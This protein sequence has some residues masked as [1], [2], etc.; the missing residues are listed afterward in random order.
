MRPVLITDE[1]A[2]RFHL[3]IR[4]FDFFGGTAEKGGLD[5]QDGPSGFSTK[6]G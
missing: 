1:I 2:P 4:F 6:G 3:L 5:F